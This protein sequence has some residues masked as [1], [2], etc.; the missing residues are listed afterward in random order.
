MSQAS[1]D[2]L[3]AH[4]RV[5]AEVTGIWQEWEGEYSGDVRAGNSLECMSMLHTWAVNGLFERHDE[6]SDS[7]ET[8]RILNLPFTFHP[9]P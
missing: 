7:D 8:P 5:C 2:N 1:A 4:N 6:D 9:K 3:A